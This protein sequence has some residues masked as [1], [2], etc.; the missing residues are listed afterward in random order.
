M[1]EMSVNVCVA[2]KMQALW[3]VNDTLIP[4][5]RLCEED[6]KGRVV[7]DGLGSLLR[8]GSRSESRSLANSL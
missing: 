6:E 5:E 3:E 4:V 8:Q 2:T 1:N 7:A